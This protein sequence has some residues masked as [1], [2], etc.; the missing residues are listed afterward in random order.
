MVDLVPSLSAPCATCREQGSELVVSIDQSCEWTRIVTNYGQQMAVTVR[1]LAA[2]WGRR[3]SMQATLAPR[4]RY[5]S[6]RDM[7]LRH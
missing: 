7:S 2:F 4:I 5:R 3:W 1:S 6:W